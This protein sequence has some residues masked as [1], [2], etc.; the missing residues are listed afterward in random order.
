V[1]CLALGFAEQPTVPL[2]RSI[3]QRSSRPSGIRSKSMVRKSVSGPIEGKRLERE[4]PAAWLPG[5]C[6]AVQRRWRFEGGATPGGSRQTDE[7]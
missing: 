2:A 1:E 4:I 5:C 7:R 6:L 3:V